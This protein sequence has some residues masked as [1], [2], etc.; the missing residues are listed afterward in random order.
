MG[1]YNS[2]LGCTPPKQSYTT[3][4]NSKG[5]VCVVMD[6]NDKILLQSLT[7]DTTCNP[8]TYDQYCSLSNPSVVVDKNPLLPNGLF[9]NLIAD[10]TVNYT[11]AP[12]PA[13]NFLEIMFLLVPF[14]CLPLSQFHSY[15]DSRT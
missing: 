8:T 15:C 5:Q 9:V 3:I 11:F 7:V 13:P 14:D 10:K 4:V 6:C 1:G 12:V 2:Y